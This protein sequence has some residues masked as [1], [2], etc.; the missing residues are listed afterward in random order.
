L[1]EATSCNRSFE[2]C[3]GRPRLPDWKTWEQAT[4]D[5]QTRDPRSQR[6]LV[7]CVSWYACCR[8]PQPRLMWPSEPPPAPSRKW[9]MS[10]AESQI[11]SRVSP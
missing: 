4:P 3:L 2:R 9:P 1:E 11:C 6:S 7:S 8:S 5:R 10:K